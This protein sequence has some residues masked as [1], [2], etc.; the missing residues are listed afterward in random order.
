MIINK[1]AI[2]LPEV[3]AESLISSISINFF[4][5]NILILLPLKLGK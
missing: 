2:T 5:S 3:E 4:T 1:Q